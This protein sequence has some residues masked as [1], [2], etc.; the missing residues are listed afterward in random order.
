MPVLPGSWYPHKGRLGAAEASGVWGEVSQAHQIRPNPAGA[1]CRLGEDP[2]LQLSPP[3]PPAPGGQGGA[4]RRLP[5]AERRGGKG[6]AR[7]SH[8]LPS[9]VAL[10]GSAQFRILA[11]E[12]RRRG[13]L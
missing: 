9:G 2:L 4:G 11:P 12:E 6:A 10:R 3:G 8:R 1:F 7:R 5:P 13:A